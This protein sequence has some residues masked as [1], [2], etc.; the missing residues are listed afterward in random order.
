MAG[1]IS[2]K[3]V[4]QVIRYTYPTFR[5]MSEYFDVN[6][7]ILK[8]SGK[9]GWEGILAKGASEVKRQVDLLNKSLSHMREMV[10][11]I[12]DVSKVLPEFAQKILGD[13]VCQRPLAQAGIIDTY[14][15]MPSLG[16]CTSIVIKNQRSSIT[17]L[18]NV[19]VT[20]GFAVKLRHEM[21]A[22]GDEKYSIGFSMENGFGFA[23]IAAPS[24]LGGKGKLLVSCY[25]ASGYY[26]DDAA[27]YIDVTPFIDG[28]R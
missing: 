19:M 26:I 27:K 5:Y 7:E 12:N 1:G 2:L 13:I 24:D 28:L 25:T 3:K 6:Y 23:L 18:N 10:N 9:K 8:N 17:E 11:G 14:I 4:A 22:Y 16:A 20:A 15:I 21:G